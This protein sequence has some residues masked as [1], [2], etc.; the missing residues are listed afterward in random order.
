MKSYLFLVVLFCTGCAM[1]NA[2]D[3]TG[4]DVVVAHTGHYFDTAIADSFIKGETTRDQVE[5]AMGKPDAVSKFSDGRVTTN[6]QYFASV[7]NSWTGQVQMKARVAIFNFDANGV[8]SSSAL[9]VQGE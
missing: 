7:Q 4:V 1:N 9:T 6:Y 8:L 2:V 3:R 5:A